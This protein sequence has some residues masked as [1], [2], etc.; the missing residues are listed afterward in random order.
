MKERPRVGAI[1]KHSLLI[2]SL[3]VADDAVDSLLTGVV[4]CDEPQETED[5]KWSN[6]QMSDKDIQLPASTC[7]LTVFFSVARF[8]LTFFARRA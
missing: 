2:V 1:S 3:L 6:P 4:S 8:T 7:S 5:G